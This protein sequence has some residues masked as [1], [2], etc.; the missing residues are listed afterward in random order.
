MEKTNDVLKFAKQGNPKAIEAIFNKQLNVKNIV[1]K[2]V[3]NDGCLKIMFESK[4]LLPQESMVA[5]VR[6]ILTG[7]KP[8]NIQAVA[9]YS[10]Q[11]G[12][13]FFSWHEEFELAEDKKVDVS[14][15]SELVQPE[16]PKLLETTIPSSDSNESSLSEAKS[17]AIESS[18]LIDTNAKPHVNNLTSKSIAIFSGVLVTCIVLSWLGWTLYQRSTYESLLT[19]A[20]KITANVS[21]NNID[22]ENLDARQKDID[23]AFLLL[24]KIPPDSGDIYQRAKKTS[25]DLEKLNF[26]NAKVYGKRG[27]TRLG[28]NNQSAIEDF[29]KAITYNPNYA[30]AYLARGAANTLIAN[31]QR[32]RGQQGDFRSVRLDLQKAV[33][34]FGQQKNVKMQ[35]QALTLLKQLDGLMALQAKEEAYKALAKTEKFLTEYLDELQSRRDGSRYFCNGRPAALIFL[36]S[37][38]ILSVSPP[39]IELNSTSTSEVQVEVYTTEGVLLKTS[40]SLVLKNSDTGEYGLCIDTIY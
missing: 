29:D 27:A 36:K 28:V 8:E 37:Y 9:I 40:R 11:S 16:A 34:L 5:G 21:S 23:A 6:K 3:L 13:D 39:A 4:Q 10:K 30:E 33:E 2:V 7:I 15:N 1:A 32:E 26:Q 19:S 17:N 20:Q 31:S 35:S 18:D 14:S 25:S 24:Y 12:D 38:K 22:S